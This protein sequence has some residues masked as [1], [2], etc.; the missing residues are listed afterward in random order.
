MRSSLT[1]GA[2]L[3]RNQTKGAKSFPNRVV[4][5]QYQWLRLARSF[6]AARAPPESKNQVLARA[7][8]LRLARVPLQP[9]S[10]SSRT[11]YT[12]PRAASK[13][14]AALLGL[15][16]PARAPHIDRILQNTFVHRGSARPAP[17]RAPSPGDDVRAPPGR[18]NPPPHPCRAAAR[19]GNPRPPQNTS[20][21]AQAP[22]RP[23][24]NRLRRLAPPP[25]GVPSPRSSPVY[26]QIIS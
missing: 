12:P 14:T 24:P 3:Q 10:K 6:C 4:W 5:P 2:E 23:W 13:K 20:N 21:S 25:R 1:V 11:H 18:P 9:A 16:A 22:P 7:C 8:C 17:G 15:E 26:L 19:L